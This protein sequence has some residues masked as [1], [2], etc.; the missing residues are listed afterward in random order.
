MP[1]VGDALLDSY[2]FVGLVIDVLS[3]D[4]NNL[5]F[6]EV[7]WYADGEVYRVVYRV[8]SERNGNSN[9]AHMSHENYSKMKKDFINKKNLYLKK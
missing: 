7:E 4:K 2:E 1:Q 8:G 3:L 9:Y 5:F 6:V